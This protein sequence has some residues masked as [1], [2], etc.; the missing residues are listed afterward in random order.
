MCVS[1]IKEKS[2]MKVVIENE[3]GRKMMRRQMNKNGEANTME[4]ERFK[5][6]TYSRYGNRNHT[7]SEYSTEKLE[8]TQWSVV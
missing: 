2:L 1:E 4:M 8:E 3:I 7:E 6:G 5:R